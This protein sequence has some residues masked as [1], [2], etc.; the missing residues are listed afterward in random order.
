MV[1]PER[2]T[3]TRE[4][5][6]RLAQ[7]VPDDEI[8]AGVRYLEYLTNRADPCLQFLLG[9]P[10]VDHESSEECERGLQEGWDDIRAGRVY[11]ADES[12]RELVL[13]ARG[14]SGLDSDRAMAVALKETR[15]HREA[16]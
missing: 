16:R 12:A 13:K 14:N 11:S 7:R 15:R 3:Q 5:L 2:G 4:Q 8:P 10:E 9:V 6:V 1:L